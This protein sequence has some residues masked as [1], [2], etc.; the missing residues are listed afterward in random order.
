MKKVF[1]ICIIMMICIN[2]MSPIS[3]ANEEETLK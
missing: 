1:Y 3:L 2:V